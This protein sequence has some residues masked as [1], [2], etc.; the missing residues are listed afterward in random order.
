MKYLLVLVPLL[1][2]QLPPA[3]CEAAEWQSLPEIQSAVETFV[4]EKTATLPGERTVTTSRIDQRLKLAKCDRLEP[5]LPVGNRLWGSSSIGVRCFAPATWS[6][7]VPVRIKVTNNVLVAARPIGSG[8]EVRAED[9]QLQQRDVTAFAGSVLTSMDQAEGKAVSMPVPAGAVLRS[10]MLRS[11][12]VVLQGQQVKLIAQGAG[13]KV[14]SE[15]QAMGN[16]T[17]GQV[18]S[19]KTRSGQIIKGIARSEGV[20]EVYF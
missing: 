12:N 18:V 4:K 8:Q 20:V 19:V 16:A 10:E 15:G 2:L 14:T 7:Y 6:L 9:V 11:S 1:I 5:Y 3:P 17:A 13:F